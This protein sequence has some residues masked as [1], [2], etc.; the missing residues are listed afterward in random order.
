MTSYGLRA[1]VLAGLGLI[2]GRNVPTPVAKRRRGSV[3]AVSIE[4]DLVFMAAMAVR[5]DLS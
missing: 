4:A 3:I 5:R 1:R 2:R